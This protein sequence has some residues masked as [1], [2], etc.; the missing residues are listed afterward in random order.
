MKYLGNKSRVSQFIEDTLKKINCSDDSALDLFSGTGSVSKI[1]SSHFKKIVSVD[2]LLLSKILTHVKL[3]PTPN[4]DSSILSEIENKQYDGFITNNYSEKVGINIFKEKIARHIDGALLFMKNNRNQFSESEFLFIMDS[5]IENADF[6]ANIMG[7]YESFYKK[8]WRKQAETDWKLKLHQNTSSCQN[9]FH[10]CSVEDFF[11]INQDSFSLVYCDSPYN[12]RQYS[13]VFH[14]PE[15]I[16][17]NI[18]VETKGKINIPKNT[19]KS[20]FS[21]K[22]NVSKSFDGL[23]NNVS[24]ITNNF[25]ISYSNEG[26]LN[27]EEFVEKLKIKFNNIEIHEIDYRKFNTNRKNKPNKVKEYLIHASK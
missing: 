19:Y 4:I 25:L 9:Y 6:R 3:N 22:R 8:G 11:L 5:I 27:K 14:V 18:E 16:C 10:N 13:S 2:I 21:Q 20:K 23:I 26:L 17:Q 15:T 1:L 7:S 24:K 12:S